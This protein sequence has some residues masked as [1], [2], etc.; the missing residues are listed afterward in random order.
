MKSYRELTPEELAAQDEAAQNEAD[1]DE[2][3]FVHD[4]WHGIVSAL[5]VDELQKLMVHI[6]GVMPRIGEL[7]DYCAYQLRDTSEP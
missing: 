2:A 3:K 6:E 7:W 5:D 1:W 4:V